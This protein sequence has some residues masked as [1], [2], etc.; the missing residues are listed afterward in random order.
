MVFR[1]RAQDGSVDR[2]SAGT[3]IDAQGKGMHLRAEDFTMRPLEQTW[4]SAATGAKYPVH[5]DVSLPK[6]GLSLD[7]TTPLASQEI[8]GESKVAPAYWEGAIRAAGSKKG[9]EI[10]GA[11]YLEMT[12]YAQPFELRQ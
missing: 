12:G 11:G 1:I 2:Y 5:W 8:D 3:F 9:K 6:L 7:L 4:R 10:R